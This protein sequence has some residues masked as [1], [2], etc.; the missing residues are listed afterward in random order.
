MALPCLGH[1]QTASVTQL[2][3]VNVVAPSPLLGSG[4][5]RNKAPAGVNVL[6]GQDIERTGIPNA[7]GAL[8][9]QTPGVALDDA[10]GN[11]FQPNLEYR[12][13][14]VSPL[15][16]NPQGL[17]VYVNGVRF[18]APFSDSVNWDLLPS[19]AIDRT[20]LEG[21]N[22]VFGLNALGGSLSIQ[23]KNGFTW[24]GGLAELY[25]GSFG[26]VD[27]SLQVRKAERQRIDLR[28]RQR[29]S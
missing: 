20:N 25:G 5:D 27:G 13:F 29:L 18:N 6:T 4:I 28:R 9:E 11:P 12:G 2:P 26:T 17:A 24:H 23:L 3:E 16:G 10:Q 1:S 21:S 7:L 22:P 19:V 14:V 8:N 15:D